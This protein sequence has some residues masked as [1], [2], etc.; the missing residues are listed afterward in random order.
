[1]AGKSRVAVFLVTRRHSTDRE[2]CWFQVNPTKMGRHLGAVTGWYVVTDERSKLHSV[3]CL[4]DIA[5][6]WY[7]RRVQRG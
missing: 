3:I 1:M 4:A 6:Q 7:Q 5:D 2:G